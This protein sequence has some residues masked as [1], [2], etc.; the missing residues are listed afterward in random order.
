M[1]LRRARRRTRARCL[2]LHAVVREG[3]RVGVPRPENGGSTE[4]RRRVYGGSNVGN[5]GAIWAEPAPWQ[6]A[7]SL[8]LRDHSA[9]RH[10][11]LPL[12]RLGRLPPMVQHRVEPG[13]P[14]PLGATWD[15]CGVNFALFSAN[16]DKVE[17]CL[18]D[19]KAS[20]RPDR[21]A[22]PEFTHEVWHGYLPDVRPRPALRVP[23]SRPYDPRAG[24]GSTTTSC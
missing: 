7:F 3:Y 22:L 1:R 24:T 21:V 12:R 2:Q 6:G 10:G 20:V 14:N 4:Q 17:L 19:P 15:G 13:L 9:S 18:F 16:A 23:G 5:S 8:G 11:D